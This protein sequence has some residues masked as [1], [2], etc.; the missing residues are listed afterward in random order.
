MTQIKRSRI[1]PRSKQKQ[2]SMVLARAQL[3]RLV[4]ERGDRCEVCPR[5][6]RVR[7]DWIGCLG[8]SQQV[9]GRHHVRK[10]SAGGTEED[11]NILLACNAGNDWIE[12]NPFMAY[13]AGLVRRRG[14]DQ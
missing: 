13:Q 4:R 2:A 11:E 10:Q 3:I 12:D 6:R 5:I 14:D 1:R 8:R 9:Q 7:Y